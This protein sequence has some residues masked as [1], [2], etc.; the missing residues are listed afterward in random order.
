V[1]ERETL[2][3]LPLG[4]V[5]DGGDQMAW[6]RA[7]IAALEARLDTHDGVATP[8]ERAMLVTLLTSLEAVSYT[9]L[10]LPT[11]CSV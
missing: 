3:A 6:V 2:T 7:G 4:A 8:E 1:S 9:H 10:T 11:I 5:A